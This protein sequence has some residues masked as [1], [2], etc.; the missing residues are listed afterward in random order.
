[1]GLDVLGRFSWVVDRAAG[2]IGATTATPEAEGI[3]WMP[4][5]A[6]DGPPIVT[7]DDGARAIL[8]SGAALSYRVGGAPAGLMPVCFVTDWSLLWGAIATPVWESTLKLNGVELPVLYG[9]LPAEADS[10][11]AWMQTGWIVGADLFRAFRVHLDFPHG[12]LGLKALG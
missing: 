9:Q 3:V 10:N 1:V 8:D 2:T 6:Q 12:R 4:L 5:D 11:L 7:L